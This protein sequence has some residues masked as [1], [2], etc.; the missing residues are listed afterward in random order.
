M[1][2]GTINAFQKTLLN[3]DFDEPVTFSEGFSQARYKKKLEEPD[4][5]R[6]AELES[7]C[8][9]DWLANDEGLPRIELPPSEWYIARKCLHDNLAPYRPQEIR[10]PK[11]TEFLPTRGHNSLEARLV[12]SDWTCTKDNFAQFARICYTHA[13]LKKAV[14]RRYKK[15]FNQKD[16]DIT[17]RES[18]MLLYKGILQGRLQSTY[19]IFVWKL[20]QITTF[21]EGSRWSSIYKNTTTRRPINIEPFGNILTQ[22]EIGTYLRNQ[23][24]SIWGIDLDHLADTH[25]VRIRFGDQIATID[26][27]NASDL[28]S[29]ELCKFVLPGFLMKRIANARSSF[30]FGP[31][32]N[33]HQVKKT[34]SMGNGFTFE[35]MSLILTAVCKVLDPEATVFGDDIIIDN[36]KAERLMTILSNVGYQVNVDKSFTSGPFRESCGG[37]YHSDEGYIES[38]DFRYPESIGDCVLI[39]NK[40]VRLAPL[41][42]SFRKLHSSLYRSIPIAL[43]G[44]PNHRFEHCDTLDLIGRSFMDEDSTVTFP[45]YFVTSKLNSGSCVFSSNVSDVLKAYQYDEDKF[46]LIPGF[47]YKANL[48]SDTIE[49]LRAHR[50]W[51]KYLMYLAAGRRTPDVLSGSGKWVKVWFITSGGE[52]FRLNALK[53]LTIT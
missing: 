17:L 47:E 21:V 36:Q 8:W 40:V 45:L 48:R 52:T 37:N 23:I 28:Q 43:R 33:Y 5:S 51:A 24:K 14:R 29:L 12:S 6:T 38:Y 26:L 19:D 39:W 20:S 15:W 35:L 9:D 41:Y 7:L 50:H 46:S 31:D 27:K 53:D 22:L 34:S 1:L 30:I 2:L 13:G 4:D 3:F 44:G 18:D 11:G 49:N 16:F 10:F 25:R 42:P 32:G